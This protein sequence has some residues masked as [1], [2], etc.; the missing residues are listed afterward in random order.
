L[1]LASLYEKVYDFDNQYLSFNFG[2][3]MEYAIEVNNLQHKYGSR[4]IYDNLN[5]KVPK[6]KV[7]GLLGKNGVGKTTLIKILMG[8]LRPAGGECKILGDD[9]HNLSPETRRKVGLLFEGHLAYEFMTIESVE[10]FFAPFYPKWERELYYG[11]TDKL[12]LPKTHKIGNMSEGQRSQVVLGLIM[13]QQP[14]VMILDDYTM[15]LDAGYRSLF[16]DY[17]IDYLKG[18]DIT[19]LVTSHIV[20]DLEEFVDDVVFLERGGL[21]TQTKLDEFL[22]DFRQYVL[23]KNDNCEIPVKDGVIKNIE[24][25]GGNTLLYSFSDKETVQKHLA[26]HNIA[27]DALEE[28]PMSFEEAFIGFTGRY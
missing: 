28:K 17:L 2:G 25:S 18:G 6:G 13:A 4:V 24:D 23:P 10:K 16:L 7:F 26:A 27:C 19:V 11:L 8:F 9:S 20:Q 1:A 15:G 3:K 14:E 12:K 22:N 21:A 5:F